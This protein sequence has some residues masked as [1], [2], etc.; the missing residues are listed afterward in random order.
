MKSL[1]IP[2]CQTLAPEDHTFRITGV[3]W[4]YCKASG[5][6]RQPV[7]TRSSLTKI[8]RNEPHNP[9][10]QTHLVPSSGAIQVQENLRKALSVLMAFNVILVC[11]YM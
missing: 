6:Q 1:I 2:A 11:W 4:Y 8:L 9:H 3:L 7:I 10:L 5:L